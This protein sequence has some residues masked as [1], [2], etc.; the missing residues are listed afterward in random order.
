M[1]TP[2]R[3]PEQVKEGLALSLLALLQIIISS[4]FLHD[5]NDFVA[6]SGN[7]LI[8]SINA[9][10]QALLQPLSILFAVSFPIFW[11]SLLTGKRVPRWLFDAV[12]I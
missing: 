8:I 2:R 7:P 1:K 3:N 10:M 4:L 9:F 5:A 12:G 6:N 11:Y